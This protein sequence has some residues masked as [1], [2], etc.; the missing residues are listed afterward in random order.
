MKQKRE[1]KRKPTID[2]FILQGKLKKASELP[3]DIDKTMGLWANIRKSNPKDYT[4]SR[5]EFNK[6]FLLGMEITR[7]CE[8]EGILPN[9]LIQAYKT[10][11]KGKKVATI[12][13]NEEIGVEKK[14]L[15]TSKIKNSKFSPNWRN[16]LI[17]NKC[18][19]TD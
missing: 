15:T 13:P 4:E 2:D 14:D 18:G 10:K 8:L 19:T 3:T 9:D 12:I 7:I 6:M 5:D 17:K 1:L 11:G 16:D